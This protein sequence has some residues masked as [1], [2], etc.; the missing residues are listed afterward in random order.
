MALGSTTRRPVRVV[1]GAASAAGAGG[2]GRCRL[3]AAA[4][5]GSSRMPGMS[6]K[7]MGVGRWF[8]SRAGA[9]SPRMPGMSAKALGVWRWFRSRAGAGGLS[10]GLSPHAPSNQGLTVVHFSAQP[11]PGNLSMH[12]LS[13]RKLSR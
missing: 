11:P 7:A 2:A 1:R 6:A 9:G 5:A 4:G 12:P 10:L 3:R 13:H 8:C